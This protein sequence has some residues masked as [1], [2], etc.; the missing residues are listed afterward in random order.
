MSKKQQENN[1]EKV[2]WLQIK[3]LPLQA[4]YR[5][6]LNVHKHKALLYIVGTLNFATSS[7]R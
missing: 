7:A 2:W 3:C 1:A 6:V 4:R 5:N